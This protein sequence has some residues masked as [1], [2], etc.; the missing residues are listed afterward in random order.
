MN[1]A[2]HADDRERLAQWVAYAAF[3]ATGVGLVL[4]GTLLPLLLARWS[5]NDAQGGVLLFLFFLGSM[6][7]ALLSRG[8]LPRS[9]AAGAVGVAAG[10][11]AMAASSPMAAFAA[12]PLYGVGMGVV[13]TSISL[14][15]SRRFAATRTA[16]MARLNMVWSVGALVGPPLALRAAGALGVAAVLNAAAVLFA[17]MGVLV[18]AAVPHA[19]AAAVETKKPGKRRMAGVVM[20]MLAAVP[21]ATGTESAM[22]GWLS[23]YAKRAGDTLGLMAGAVTCFWAGML[24]SRLLQSHVRAAEV[25]RTLTLRWGPALIVA[26]VTMVIASRG[27]LGTVTGAFLAGFALGPTYPLLLSLVLEHGEG[28]NAVFVAGGVGAA[29]LPLL[30]GVVS[31]HT[32]SLRAGL[33]VPLAGAAGLTAIC[34]LVAR[35]QKAGL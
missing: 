34:W 8:V 4:P 23:T 18:W 13:M 26:A 10:A 5:L 2:A 21:L 24:L 35:E 16:Q 32:G 9:A 6:G 17:A 12:V 30:T 33:A 20:L 3:A 31:Q 1:V 7:G 27:G 22:G 25:S 19:P 14:L 28:G 15:Q 11:A 29:S